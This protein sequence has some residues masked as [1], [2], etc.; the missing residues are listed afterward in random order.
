MA[1]D[2]LDRRRVFTG[3]MNGPVGNQQPPVE[4]NPH[5]VIRGRHQ[6][7]RIRPLRDQLAEPA[8]RILFRAPKTR[9]GRSRRPVEI[10]VPV[11]PGEEKLLEVVAPVVPSQKPRAVAAVGLL[12]ARRF[13]RT[14]P[15]DGAE[16]AERP[17]AARGYLEARQR[18]RFGAGSRRR[19]MRQRNI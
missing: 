19:Q 5:P 10:D 8:D 16:P 9:I 11:G 14:A 18:E 4:V 2:E 6:R 3:A 7:V 12:A 17:D 1:G 15:T 13:H